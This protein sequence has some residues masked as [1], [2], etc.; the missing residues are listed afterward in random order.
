M[1]METKL[2]AIDVDD[3]AALPV[4][5]A[6]YGMFET[7]T[8]K[9]PRN[10]LHFFFNRP[11]HPIKN[12]VSRLA[13]HVD[14]RADNGYVLIP[15]S[16]TKDGSYRL[17]THRPVADL[18]TPLL[19]RLIES[20]CSEKSEAIASEVS[21]FSELSDSS[22]R[23]EAVVRRTL[24]RGAGLRNRVLLDLSRGLK[25]DC[26][27]Q[28]ATTGE[29]K[30]IVRRWH[31]LAMPVIGTKSFDVT[32][33]DFLE[34][35]R[36]ARC[37]LFGDLL[38]AALE[39]AKQTLPPDAAAYEDEQ[40]KTLIALC[41]QLAVSHPKHEFFLSSHVLNQLMD[42]PQPSAFRRL[43]MLVA[44]GVLS[45]VNVGDARRATRYQ[46]KGTI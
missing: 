13:P 19:K 38:R 26:Q 32:W 24:P 43:R 42:L 2:L 29:L 21:D 35:W 23:I 3:L 11:N 44:D 36:H 39:Q 34:A 6:A 46:W 40:T 30:A 22:A 27:L 14:V 15:L 9:T 20:E 8:T 33:A 41:H 18:P 31:T 45:V 7:L 1:G 25:F 12:S 10:G 37:P 5:R 28:T 4:L 17:E 16:S